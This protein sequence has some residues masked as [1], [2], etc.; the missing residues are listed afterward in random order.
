MGSYKE[1]GNTRRR[2]EGRNNEILHHQKGNQHVKAVQEASTAVESRAP[3]R[4]GPCRVNERG[5]VALW[6]SSFFSPVAKEGS[7]RFLEIVIILLRTRKARTCPGGEGVL[8]RVARPRSFERLQ[9]TADESQGKGA[10]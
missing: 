1:K 4:S 5:E 7:R 10:A 2:M 6:S 8:S 9:R 3:R